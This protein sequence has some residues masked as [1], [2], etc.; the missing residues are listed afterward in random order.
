MIFRIAFGLA[1]NSAPEHRWRR[2]AV[3]VSAAVFMLLVLAGSS[4]V[5]MV[6][7]G[8]ERVEQRTALL[9]QEPS[10]TDLIVVGGDDVWRGEQF[11]VVWIDPAGSAKPVLPP[12]MERLPE[13]GGAVVSPAL[14]RLAS[15]EPS[16][17]ARYPDR[18]VLGP[19]G[20][21]NGD[22]LFAYVRVPEGRTLAGY[23]HAV[24]VRAF[25]PPSG[26]AR[27]ST[28]DP[29]AEPVSVV[30]AAEGVLGF[31]IVP[32]FVV[33]A[34]GLAAASGLRDRRFEVLRWIGAR[35][36]TLAALAVL[37][38]LILALPGLLV[39]TILWGLVSPRL[40]RV[41]LVGSDPVRGDLGL[42]WWFLAAELG[43][44]VAA[45]ALVAVIV[46]AVRS[47]RGTVRLRPVSQ[48]A[49]FTPLRIAPLG[50]ALV[51]FML[52][53]FLRGPIGG[54]LNF[55]GILATVVGVPLI[56][57]GVLRA[58]G[59]ALGRLESVSVSIAG[60]GLEWDP[61]RTA[62]PFLGVAVLVV[63]TLAS[64]GYL[65][66]ARDVEASPLQNG[67]TQAVLVEW[68]DPRPDDSA[69]LANALDTGLVVPTRIKENGNALF[70]GATCRQLASYFAGVKCA[71]ESLYKL[72]DGTARRIVKALAVLNPGAEVRLAPAEDVS[73]GGSAL[74][75]GDEPLGTLEGRVRTAA[76]RTLPAPNV[77]STLA[78]VMQE[79]PL[80]AWIVG[81]V[82]VGVIALGIGCL[83]SLVDR[84]LDTHK[85]RRHLLNL[86]V[87]PHKLAAIEAWRFAA[88]YG[89]VVTLGFSAGLAIVALMVLPDISMPWKAIGVAFGVAVITGLVGTVSVAFFGARSFR[90]NPE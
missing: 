90:E 35:Q 73:T 76:M 53:W 7:R 69:R 30:E 31:L 11:P 6:Q 75:L 88:P 42:P 55:G 61:L 38:T 84:L 83:V 10:P 5:L 79:S 8:A 21:R 2:V 45:T 63:V 81:G 52:G 13:P 34:V 18:L 37:E 16:L 71:P 29:M 25:G 72:P 27:F 46:T 65:A 58:V 54:T 49:A 4:V 85:H 9:A 32:G 77:S 36:W 41:P 40:E 43:A 17:A 24:R 82:V 66:L 59:A 67:E 33:L 87:S 20:V 50:A 44:G 12:G 70:V 56:F 19:E 3:P 78:N 26:A 57:P 22:E 86:G 39:S 68:L 62:R 15:R 64:N 60:R 28:L 48:K 89:T 51:A 74:V 23:E 47:Q 14:D 1:R 80:V